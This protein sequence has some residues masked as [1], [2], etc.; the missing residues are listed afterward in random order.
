MPKSSPQPIDANTVMRR[1]AK[2]QHAVVFDASDLAERAKSLLLRLN[3]LT[4]VGGL[5]GSHEDQ[6]GAFDC[7]LQ[8]CAAGFAERVI[9]K[10]SPANTAAAV[11][12]LERG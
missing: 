8:L 2:G 5:L 9:G 7:L 3:G 12:D 6:S 4:P 11:V 10:A 1:T